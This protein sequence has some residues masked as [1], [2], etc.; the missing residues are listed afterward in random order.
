MSFL[1]PLGFLGLLLA[2]PI[3]LLYMLRLRR[4][5]VLVSSTFLWQQVLQDNEANTPWQRLRRNLLLLLQLLILALLAFALARPFVI[6]PAVSTGQI[7]LLLDASASMNATDAD[8]NTRFEA[9]QAAAL[10]IISTMTNADS[11]TVI[12]VADVPEVLVP[13]TQDRALLRSAVEGAAPSDARADW[14][15]ALTLAAGTADADSQDFSVVIV[16]DG[17]LGSNQGLP[18]VAGDVE[19]VPVG[20]SAGNVAITA[21]ATRSLG[22]GNPQ[23]FTEMTNYGDR[24]AEVVFDLT[25]D[26]EILTAERFTLPPGDT[27][28]LVSDSLPENFDVI[29]AGI[30]PASGSETEDFLPTDNTAWA[31]S[32]R[33]DVTEALV[34][35]GGN[36]FVDRVLGSLPTVSH[37]NAS[38][39]QGIPSREF[40]LYVFDSY[41]PDALPAGDMLI[42]N[43][44]RDVPGL[45]TLGAESEQTTNPRALANDD[46]TAFLD[47]ESVNIRVFRP[48]EAAWAEPL[49]SVD[50]GGVLY[51]GENDG[52]QIAVLTF[53]LGESDLPLQIAF[54]IMM[55]NLLDWYR[56]EAAS[57]AQ[58]SLRVGESLPIR[59]PAVA[60]RVRVTKPNG[61]RREFDIVSD[62]FIY[63]DTDELGVYEVA[64]FSGSRELQTAQFAVNLFDVNES[65]ITPRGAV[66]LGGEEVTPAV[67]EQQ[68]QREFWQWFA[69]AALIILMLE[70]FLYHRRV[71]GPGAIFQPIIRREGAR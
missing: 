55:S 58:T 9:A 64:L 19:Y 10:E 8:G 46:R 37:I 12:R 3:V 51:A 7:A 1:T 62:L 4:R 5:E 45:F 27:V 68:G 60:D 57:F 42:I 15:A 17:G 59:P 40:D 13:Q 49:I 54:P 32:D 33:S 20:S 30:T 66:Q 14:N 43:P 25:V 56:P 69:L 38:P 53:P 67:R 21:L 63:A 39:E 34:I 2:G 22:G 36:V 26:G 61:D 28:P 41:L 29:E 70:W 23:L 18:G 24:E 44:P 48:L 47:F 35:S 31:V 16:G 11:M 6:V 52:R 71:N 50:G 65:D